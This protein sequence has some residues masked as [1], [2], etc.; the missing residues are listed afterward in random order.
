MKKLSKLQLK[1]VYEKY[2]DWLINN[3]DKFNLEYFE[4]YAKKFIN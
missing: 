1:E 2:Y 4:R 3:T